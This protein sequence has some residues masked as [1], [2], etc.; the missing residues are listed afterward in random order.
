MWTGVCVK[1]E[2]NHPDEGPALNGVI[3]IILPVSQVVL[4]SQC[5]ITCALSWLVKKQ[6]YTPRCDRVPDIKF[7]EEDRGLKDPCT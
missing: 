5:F 1:E 4:P 3:K 7:A 2:K 6:Q